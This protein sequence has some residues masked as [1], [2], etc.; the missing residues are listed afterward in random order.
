MSIVVRIMYFL[1]LQDFPIRLFKNFKNQE[2]REWS[3][4][5]HSVVRPAHFI[6]HLYTVIKTGFFPYSV[7][8]S[9]VS[10]ITASAELH[11][12]DAR[13]TKLNILNLCLY[14]VKVFKQYNSLN[15]F[16]FL[17]CERIILKYIITNYSCFYR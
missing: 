11:V 14:L 16:I 8:S 2:S 7:V 3:Q 13:K 15:L 1:L 9:Y 12:P 17:S 5:K 6:L 4:R 10:S